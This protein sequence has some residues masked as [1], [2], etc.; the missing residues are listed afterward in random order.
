LV[1]FGNQRKVIWRG[2]LEKG[3]NLLVLP[4]IARNLKGGVLTASIHHADERKQFKLRLNVRKI[5]IHGDD[6][7][8][9]RSESDRLFMTS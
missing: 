3:R 2:D 6:T 8:R 1:G 7:K 9:L 5:E 4:V